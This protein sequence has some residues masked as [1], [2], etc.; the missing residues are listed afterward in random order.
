MMVLAHGGRLAAI[1]VAV[2][3]PLAI[4]AGRLLRGLLFHVSDTDP[5]VL[6]AVAVIAI[7]VALTASYIPARRATR[8]DPM[9]ALRAQ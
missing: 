2:G 3:I 6:A 8:V 9:I 4:A 7:I 1:G 5:A